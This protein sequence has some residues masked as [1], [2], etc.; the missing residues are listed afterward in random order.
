[1]K[2]DT[3]LEYQ[4]VDLELI[5][6][7][8]EATSS[9]E[10]ASLLAAKKTLDTATNTVGKLSAEAGEI[11]ANHGKIQ[12]KIDDLKTKLDEYT[13]LLEDLDDVKEAEYYLKEVDGIISE[14]IA[15]EKEAS[16]EMNR[17][18][19]VTDDYKKT[20]DAGTK[21]SEGFKQA[22]AVY[23]KFMAD[24]QP[25]ANEIKAKLDALQKE[26]PQ[27]LIAKYK[28]LRDPKKM[29]VF[30]EYDASKKICGRC[31]ME[32]PNDVIEKLRQSGDYA[33][34]PNCRRI[35]YLP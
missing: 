28:A 26:I 13:G 3:I 30:V 9:K 7:E 4:R 21:A 19:G 24:L 18:D 35:N 1:M 22:K 33:E 10:L 16:K 12:S 31:R 11:I 20:W 5:A 34:C 25:K 6:L 23:D 2:F 29:P 17:I 15:L 27:E 8:T 14:I 32:M